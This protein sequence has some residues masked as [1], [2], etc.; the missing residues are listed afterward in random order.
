MPRREFMA[1]F[2][3]VLLGG[4]LLGSSGAWLSSGQMQR[5]VREELT[6]EELRIINHS[7]MAK[8]LLNYYK[9][10]YSCAESILLVSLKFM[11][12]PEELFWAASGFGGGIGHKDLCGFLTGGIMAIGLSVGKLNAGREEA[13]KI[14]R[15]KVDDYWKWWPS[16]APFHCSEI[17]TEERTSEVCKRVGQLAAVKL[18]DLIRQA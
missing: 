1:A 18:E 5:K 7:V 3:A 6:P 13:I 15:K 2:P 16:L 4:K 9:N 12:R 17:K 11:K 14:C 10:G 8:D